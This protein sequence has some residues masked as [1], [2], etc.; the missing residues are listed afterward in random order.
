M[1]IRSKENLVGAWAFLVGVILAVLVAVLS[2]LSE[3]FKITPLTIG[4]LA[5]IGIVLGFFVSE[6]SVQTF[7]IAAVSLVIVSYAG[8]SGMVMGAAIIGIGIGKIISSMLQTLL[9]M[10]VPATIVVALKSMFSIA[11]G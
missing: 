6:R 3:L 4:I 1:V 10:F 9:A 5:L 8:I 2:N 11:N 7:L